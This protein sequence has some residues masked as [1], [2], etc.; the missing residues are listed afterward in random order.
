MSISEG[1]RWSSIHIYCHHK[2]AQ[3]DLLVRISDA[4]DNGAHPWFFVRYWLGGPHIRLRVQDEAGGQIARARNICRDFFGERTIVDLDETSFYGSIA[5][6]L[7]EG[8]LD[9]NALPWYSSGTVLAEPYVPEAE[10]YGGLDALPAA[11]EMFVESSALSARVI[12]MTRRPAARLVAAT[13]IMRT[14]AERSG[15]SAKLAP[16]GRFWLGT[17]TPGVPFESVEAIVRAAREATLPSDFDRHIDGLAARL[18]ALPPHLSEDR[19]R[20]IAASQIHMTNNRLGVPTEWEGVIS[21]HLW[22]NA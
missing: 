2:A 22:G 20:L 12:R 4:L 9:D 16:Y 13:Y 21:N 5:P 6:E 11:E 19:R 3:D 17:R 1:D 15:L 8:Q 7:R 14:V 18:G 10:R